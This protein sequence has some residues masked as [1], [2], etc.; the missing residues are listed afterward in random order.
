[1]SKADGDGRSFRVQA[2]HFVSPPAADLA[3]FY[4]PGRRPQFWI[5]LRHN[6]AREKFQ[7]DVRYSRVHGWRA[8]R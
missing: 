8:V 3:G 2:I 7:N 1:M 4:I 5:D 6:D